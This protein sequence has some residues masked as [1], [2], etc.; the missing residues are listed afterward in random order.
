MIG[1]LLSGVNEFLVPT[2][3]PEG[4]PY[5]A[6]TLRMARATLLANLGATLLSAGQGGQSYDQRAQTLGRLGQGVDAYNNVIT[7]D[8]DRK[9]KQLGLQKGQQD[10]VMGRLQMQQA[11]QQ[12][13]REQAWR[14]Y[15][16]QG[17]G[18]S[19]T[20]QVA[21]QAAG[22]PSGARPPAAAPAPVAA[23][24]TPAATAPPSS[25][26]T[27]AAPASTPSAAA[28]AAANAQTWW[29]QLN[30]S[31]EQARVILAQPNRDEIIKQLTVDRA[32]ASFPMGD[33]KIMS[34]EAELRKEFTGNEAVK[35]FNEAQRNL[36]AMQ[37]MTERAKEDGAGVNDIALVYAFFKTI[38]PASVVRE[39]E[40]DTVAKNMGLPDRIVSSFTKLSGG[41]FLPQDV[42]E[43]LVRVAGNYLVQR[44]D[45]VE[46]LKGQYGDIARG[47]NLNPTNVTP[48]P[49]SP[50]TT[51]LVAERRLL[52]QVTKR[53]VGN[54]TEEQLASIPYNVLE[55]M[56]PAQR[57][58]LR[59]RAMAL[60]GEIFTDTQFPMDAPRV[61]T[62][63]PAAPPPSEQPW[64][65]R[66]LQY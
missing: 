12:M 60:Q 18:P 62:S 54:L 55:K 6:E 64:Y 3:V 7:G 56:T 16:Q 66:I 48:D 43:E 34:A 31:P 29:Q 33:E 39:T 30:L 10:L 53:N 22:V 8:A 11:Q 37:S 15:L 57:N 63:Q 36:T 52:S 47:R 24:P 41:G 25:A 5:D 38:D 13:A 2:S 59:R 14:D 28:P 65:R 20:T 44:Y 26:P 51:D 40:F 1:G 27:P 49:R 23:P 19:A 4:A 32:K 46:R 42:R 35:T 58:M 9:M 21:L 61:D 17:L 50:A 45:D